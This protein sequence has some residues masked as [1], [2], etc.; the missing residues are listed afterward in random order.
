MS[1]TRSEHY[2]RNKK[3]SRSNKLYS[4]VE[5]RKKRRR[6]NRRATN[7]KDNLNHHVRVVIPNG[8]LPARTGGEA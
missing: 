8:N 5:R 7:K 3:G 6:E 1:L 2:R 4:S